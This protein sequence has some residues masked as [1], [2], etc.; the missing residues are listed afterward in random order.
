MGD[1]MNKTSLLNRI[2]DVL[3]KAKK[4]TNPPNN[5][6]FVNPLKAAELEVNQ[7]LEDIPADKR[8]I[9]SF[10][11]SVNRKKPGD[12]SIN[13]LGY[14]KGRLAWLRVDK[15]G[16]KYIVGRNP[17]SVL[18]PYSSVAKDPANL[19]PK[20]LGK[21]KNFSAIDSTHV[22]RWV[23]DFKDDAANFA[24]SFRNNN[25]NFAFKPADLG[26]GSSAID[27]QKTDKEE[28]ITNTPLALSYYRNDLRHIYCLKNG[29]YRIDSRGDLVYIITPEVEDYVVD[30]FKKHGIKYN[31]FNIN[32]VPAD[33]SKVNALRASINLILRDLGLE[34]NISA[35]D[36]KKLYWYAN[37]LQGFQVEP[38]EFLSTDWKRSDLLDP[39]SRYN[40]YGEGKKSGKRKGYKKL[41][42]AGE[43]PDPSNR[44]GLSV[45]VK[46][47]KIGTRKGL[48]YHEHIGID[49]DGKT[50]TLPWHPVLYRHNS[51][52]AM[53]AHDKEDKEWITMSAFN[54]GKRHEA[55]IQDN[56]D[57]E[58]RIWM[59][60]L[61][62]HKQTN[63][64]NGY[65][66]FK[67]ARTIASK[68]KR[69]A[70][71]LEIQK[72]QQVLDH[73][74]KLLA[75]MSG[76]DM[77]ETA[78]TEQT[79][80][81]IKNRI[82]A[83][84]SRIETIRQAL[85]DD[86][87]EYKEDL[88]SIDDSAR[89]DSTGSF[90]I[91][92]V[93]KT[94]V[95]LNGKKYKV[96]EIYTDEKN[97]KVY[98]AK[99]VNLKNYYFIDSPYAERKWLEVPENE[100]P[101]IF[102]R[103][104][105]EHLRTQ[106]NDIPLNYTPYEQ[107]LVND[108]ESNS[109][110]ATI[111]E[112]RTRHLN[113]NLVPYDTTDAD[114]VKKLGG[115]EKQ[116]EKKIKE[117]TKIKKDFQAQYDNKKSRYLAK[118]RKDVFEG[119][120]TYTDRPK[121]VERFNDYLAFRKYETE[122]NQGKHGHLNWDE[123]EKYAELTRFVNTTL[124]N[125]IDNS[126]AVWEADFNKQ[127][128]VQGLLKQIQD[129]GKQ[130][131]E[132]STE[133]RRRKQRTEIAPVEKTI[134][135]FALN[136]R[137]PDSSKDA[138]NYIIDSLGI[139]KTAIAEHP[140]LKSDQKRLVWEYYRTYMKTSCKYLYGNRGLEL[141]EAFD[142]QGFEFT[143]S[144]KFKK[145]Y[146]K[147]MKEVET[148]LEIT[149]QYG[150]ERVQVALKELDILD[151]E[152]S[153]E[154]ERYNQALKIVDEWDSLRKSHLASA[155]K[156]FL[157]EHGNVCLLPPYFNDQMPVSPHLGILVADVLRL[158]ELRPVEIE[159][160]NKLKVET[161][162]NALME[163]PDFKAML[164]I[165]HKYEKLANKV[166]PFNLNTYLQLKD[167]AEGGG[168]EEI[169]DEEG[170]VLDSGMAT[171]TSEVAKEYAMYTNPNSVKKLNPRQIQD[172]TRQFSPEEIKELNALYDLKL[173]LLRA[174]IEESNLVDEAQLGFKPNRTFDADAAYYDD[175]RQKRVTAN[176]TIGL[177][178][179]KEEYIK[180]L[181]NKIGSID[182][183]YPSENLQRIQMEMRFLQHAY[184]LTSNKFSQEQGEVLAHFGY[185]NIEPIRDL[186]GKI[187]G[188][189]GYKL[190]K[191]GNLKKH[192][193]NPKAYI[194]PSDVFTSPFQELGLLE[195]ITY[196]S[197]ISANIRALEG[198]GGGKPL[199]V[200][201]PAPI[202]GQTDY[203]K[204][205]DKEKAPKEGL[206]WEGED[207]S[208]IMGAPA[209]IGNSIALWAMYQQLGRGRAEDSLYAKTV[210]LK[211]MQLPLPLIEPRR[212]SAPELY[213]RFGTDS[214]GKIGAL[215]RIPGF[216]KHYYELSQ[217]H[218]VKLSSVHSPYPRDYDEKW[219]LLASLKGAVIDEALF[220]KPNTYLETEGRDIERDIQQ[221]IPD[222]NM[223][224]LVLPMGS[225]P[226]HGFGISVPDGMA[227]YA[228]KD[229]INRNRKGGKLPPI[230]EAVGRDRF[231]DDCLAPKS[232]KTRDDAIRYFMK[233]N[234]DSTLLL[235]KKG[236]M[237]D[238]NTPSDKV[239]TD[240]MEIVDKL[241]KGDR[242]NL[243]DSFKDD[244]YFYF[245]RPFMDGDVV[246]LF[247]K[248]NVFDIPSHILR[249]PV[250]T[251]KGP[252]TVGDQLTKLPPE[253][254]FNWARTFIETPQQLTAAGGVVP[255]KASFEPPK[256]AFKEPLKKVL[257]LEKEQANLTK[258]LEELKTQ[259]K[260]TVL[261]WD[262]KTMTEVTKPD[263]MYFRHR[264]VLKIQEYLKRLGEIDIELKDVIGVSPEMRAMVA[265]QHESDIQHEEDLYY[266]LATW[267]DKETFKINRDAASYFNDPYSSRI[268]YEA[269]EEEGKQRNRILHPWQALR[270]DYD[271]LDIQIAS[272]DNDFK[273]FKWSSPEEQK[274]ATPYMNTLHIK[275]DRLK[276]KQLMLYDK[277][278]PKELEERATRERDLAES[279]D[280]ENASEILQLYRERFG[281]N[282]IIEESHINIEQW[283]QEMEDA[284][285]DLF[286][287][288]DV[289]TPLERI[290]KELLVVSLK[291]QIDT[292][293][294]LI[295]T[296]TARNKAIDDMVGPEP[297]A[298]EQAPRGIRA[299]KTMEEGLKNIANPTPEE[300]A[301]QDAEERVAG[302][303]GSSDAK[304]IYSPLHAGIAE[305]NKREKLMENL[306]KPSPSSL[307]KFYG[308]TTPI[309]EPVPA[310]KTKDKKEKTKKTKDGK[311]VVRHFGEDASDEELQ[312]IEDEGV[313]S[314]EDL[315]L[316]DE[317]DDIEQ[318]GINTQEFERPEDS[319]EAID[320][321]TGIGEKGIGGKGLRMMEKSMRPDSSFFETTGKPM[322]DA[323]LL[324]RIN[325]TV[326][327]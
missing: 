55:G 25:T 247:P 322:S 10:S 319:E 132:L 106:A 233:V 135:D 291:K 50:V 52:E 199:D 115:V 141:F 204:L 1:N 61:G 58:S 293:E 104:I 242:N 13:V 313:P 262:P 237:F 31:S 32:G 180:Y 224:T 45:E 5:T 114:S 2:E 304:D 280:P 101:Q 86:E 285:K 163:S 206:G 146:D 133:F 34:E 320:E 67:Q 324:Y 20:S 218:K 323:G 105:F 21:E 27:R 196:P 254:M 36:L 81:E 205:V 121:I 102:V 169:T 307:D 158:N 234:S 22:D 69:K 165:K 167:R 290:Q 11:H 327:K 28:G 148:A 177:G 127:E 123:K 39:E 235:K 297:K 17:A 310:E 98:Y 187:I 316:P 281:N 91:I 103:K 4:V 157:Q 139:Y 268:P 260:K 78:E 270:E 265:A 286:L 222:F 240:A 211:A 29:L 256:L 261:V 203:M 8:P 108:A 172:L 83:F 80:L 257:A 189:N 276:H 74:A 306:N 122:A 188:L 147:R 19:I 38:T 174:E 197:D 33:M 110:S 111:E 137:T 125:V 68:N 192:K 321:I 227:G 184:I 288:K 16:H 128:D 241:F 46:N 238:E 244:E 309:E 273:Y 162:R 107:E 295:K 255:P 3:L 298:P 120:L 7:Y 223:D 130:L 264:N 155:R 302:V 300:K 263:P 54:D 191:D 62:V 77:P 92:Y 82:V 248:Y 59:D 95:E 183:K 90:Q 112:M 51:N 64:R 75:D 228:T 117:L 18:V 175:L 94:E 142:K 47:R 249:F 143:I 267:G 72:F 140:A 57:N 282:R 35:E 296:N 152:S 116:R 178:R 194:L 287:N 37:D 278:Y 245:L 15:V 232:F 299:P 186:S 271:E 277:M 100:K 41:E 118:Y 210:P 76:S 131:N 113:E 312:D 198:T 315:E 124:D 97:N 253:E 9:F 269:F 258:K 126:K 6:P 161:M 200:R 87:I 283:K 136:L 93:D 179:D 109:L 84:E 150:F 182:R 214:H 159:H 48:F 138:V 272:I 246:G 73:N 314:F 325:K 134:A 219:H 70:Q 201:K 220:P 190:D 289:G 89:E 301:L 193:L 176:K 153:E 119:A 303:A 96:D 239:K 149:K 308:K 209:A 44:T 208:A 259:Q 305:S 251:S 275:Q 24:A 252:S 26:A 14:I 129:Y 202:K 65:D 318:R 181:E 215:S 170:N 284:S 145:E 279:Q 154:A 151:P 230:K 207:V 195:E 250:Q 274:K 79:K 56:V 266:R 326:K 30:Q 156:L 49:Q 311:P 243:P 12:M 85:K 42:Y 317:G 225:T 66:G 88:Q 164:D 53:A 23:S 71:N 160:S 236:H 171:G 294:T 173:E 216:L 292:E 60:S 226:V 229:E 63:I 168:V 166:V 231:V 144:S 217:I 43:I 212:Y 40:E 185:T 99:S 213:E 221:Y